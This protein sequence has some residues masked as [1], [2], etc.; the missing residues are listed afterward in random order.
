MD[1]PAAPPTIARA[2]LLGLFPRCGERTLFAGVARL[3]TR[4]RACGLDLSA[5]DVGDGPAAFLTLS[6]VTLIG[7][8]AVTVQL[9]IEP[10]WWV[11]ALFRAAEEA[12]RFGA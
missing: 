1:Q 9:R 7:A 3:A 6:L 4:C 8:A 2:A 10:P 11:Q 12:V 5:F